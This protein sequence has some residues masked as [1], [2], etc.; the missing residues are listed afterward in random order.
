MAARSFSSTVSTPEGLARPLA[1]ARGDVGSPSGGLIFVSGTLTQELDRIAEQVR[2]SWRGV[3]V[4]IVPAAGVITE[5]GEIQSGAGASGILWSGG[6]VVPFAVRDG[7]PPGSMA[8]GLSAAIFD[9]HPPTD[10]PGR[11]AARPGSRSEASVPSGR[12]TTV[13]LFA[14]A[15]LDGEALGDACGATPGV[16]LFGGGSVGGGPIAVT[17]SGEILHGKVGGLA[18][19][20]LAP[21][22][23]ES[24]PACRLLGPL[25]RIDRATNG[26]VLEIDGVPAL[27]RLSSL[28]PEA[29]PGAAAQPPM[30][31]VALGD[32]A[33]GALDDGTPAR[34]VVRMMRGIDPTRRGVLVGP[35]AQP[36]IWM[37]FALRDAAAAKT[38]LEGIARTVAQ[39]ALGAAPRFAIYLSCASRGQALYGVDDVEAR[40]LRQ[41]FGDL[42]IAGMHSAFE[43]IPWG[44]GKAKLAQHTG[45]LALFR[46]PS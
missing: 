32:P 40:I 35:E 10:P 11:V 14:E 42:P 12:S 38:G 18:I 8:D 43:I 3:P 9:A 16:C 26:M 27:D 31:L 1:A 4:C 13:V 45:V 33:A 44:P 7:A 19:R 34:V 2:A 22:L 20:D 25:R 39:Q 46:S 29:S 15:S 36:G 37:A 30:V 24:T 5:R 23:V 41:R 6:K 21:P 28:V 17:A